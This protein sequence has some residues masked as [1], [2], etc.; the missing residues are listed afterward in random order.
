[1][2]HQQ[3]VK[4]VSVLVIITSL[5]DFGVDAE[6]SLGNLDNC[7]APV[8]KFSTDRRRFVYQPYN[9]ICSELDNVNKCLKN[10][11][12]KESDSVVVLWWQGKSDAFTYVCGAQSAKDVMTRNMCLYSVSTKQKI[13]KCI[14]GYT[15][16]IYSDATAF[17]GA[18]K[19]YFQCLEDTVK[20]CGSHVTRV[21]MTM[22]Y[23][24]TKPIIDSRGCDVK[25]PAVTLS[26]AKQTPSVL[27]LTA[28]FV[29]F[30]T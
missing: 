10:V 3:F 9:T 27:L 16:L 15:H 18:T 30:C 20:G 28:I 12:C 14:S 1:M 2:C 8:V 19:N 11:G 22:T 7:I 21:Y 13:D 23:K 24:F 29:Y 5:I 26:A 6:C 17:C 4:A 25:A